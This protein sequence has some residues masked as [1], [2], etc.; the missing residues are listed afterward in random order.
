MAVNELVP[1]E[2]VAPPER[3]Q[4]QRAREYHY[5]PSGILGRLLETLLVGFFRIVNR[6]REW[7]RLPKWLALF[8]LGALRIELRRHNLHDTDGDLTR[9][10]PAC[11]FHPLP[12]AR[13]MR[14]PNG[15]R[16]DLRYP[17]MGCRGSRFG[18]NVP[19]TIT[20]PDLSR[21]F[22]PDPLLVSQRLLARKKFIA[23]ESLNLLAAAWIQFQVHDWFAHESEEPSAGKDLR[24]PRA[25]DW[26]LAEMVVPRTKPD[27]DVLT[28]LDGKYP[29]YRNKNTQ[30][31]DGSQVYGETAEKTKRLREDPATRS[32]CSRG[33]LY[34]TDQ[35]LLPID[36]DSGGVLSGSTSNW[37]LGLEIMHTLFAKEHNAICEHIAAHVRGFTDEKI[38][39]TARLVNCAL[40][41]KIHTVEWTPGI[42]GHPAIKPGMD[43]NWMGL[44]GHWLG[45][46]GARKIA[47]FLPE[48]LA[49]EVLTGVPLSAQDHHGAPFS[50]TEE[51]AAIYRMHPLL[52]DAVVIER[53]ASADGVGSYAL[54][55]IAFEKAR[56]PLG[57]GATID[58]LV[59]S[60]GIAHPG[61]ITIG[62]YPAF[63]RELTIRDPETGRVQTLDLAAV[64]ILRDRER[65][66]PRYNEFR[67]HLGKKPVTSWLELA[68]G[69]P[70]LARELEDVYGGDLEAVDT[71]VGL[72]C[73][74]P[75]EGFGFSDTA[76]RLFILMASRRL[77]SDRFFTSD[78]TE[79]LYTKPGLEWIRDSGMKEVILRHHANLAPAFAGVLNPFWPW[80]K[81]G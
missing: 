16:N 18:R 14:T 23:A 6:Y 28:P 46:D 49:K 71:M 33:R 9:E 2:Q 1:S 27:P 53:H 17:A 78:Y 24:L 30:W 66:V 35:G 60:L 21:L 74:P 50:L 44:I 57:A 4:D 3:P 76:F 38:F 79:D 12:A 25:G 10:K 8:N 22:T 68:G 77:K 72:F 63:L 73:E 5:E 62:N 34:L 39:Q 70:D 7:H 67:R 11:P 41:A 31:W 80:R 52:P 58:D 15:T 42:L 26:K 48:F 45:E 81:N 69:R 54:P 19:R 36:P 64:D 32:P 13:K 61:A 59:Y 51:F 56:T 40:M 75:P 29:A 47:P 65:G 20:A 43:A 55:E 37:W